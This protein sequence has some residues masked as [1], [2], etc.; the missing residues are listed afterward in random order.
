MC[1]TINDEVR[2]VATPEKV[3]DKWMYMLII[4]SDNE[5]VSISLSYYCDRLH[6]I[7]TLPSWTSFDSSVNPSGYGGIYAPVFV[8]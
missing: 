4:G 7:F 2:A 1:A 8:K 6:R 3:D 5:G